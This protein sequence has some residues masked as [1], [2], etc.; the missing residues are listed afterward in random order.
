MARLSLEKAA[1][2]D[3]ELAMIDVALNIAGRPK[4]DFIRVDGAVD[5]ASH[6]HRVGD[7]QAVDR[8]AFGYGDGLAS[9]FSLHHAINVHG[10][11]EV[12]RAH[13]G[14]S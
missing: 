3:V 4:N 13:D 12:N 8:A 2:L 1:D 9:D 7:D 11:V 14:C 5:L 10:P 6:R